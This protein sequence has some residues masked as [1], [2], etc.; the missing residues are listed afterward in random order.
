MT[1][2]PAKVEGLRAHGVR[3]AGRLPHLTTPNPHNRFYL[4][5]KQRRAGHWLNLAEGSNAEAEPKRA[6]NNPPAVL[7]NSVGL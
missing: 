6:E 2:N 7:L 1:N 4:L 5:T 3:V